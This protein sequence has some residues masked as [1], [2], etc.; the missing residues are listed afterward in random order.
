MRTVGRVREVVPSPMSYRALE[1][2]KLLNVAS[3]RRW[4]A[5]AHAPAAS[6]IPQ[7]PKTYNPATSW[8]RTLANSQFKTEFVV[9]NSFL[10][11]K[12]HRT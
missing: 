9:Q 11:S 10:S 1:M 2:P 6:C 4:I 8:W 7:H 12:R 3:W 5:S